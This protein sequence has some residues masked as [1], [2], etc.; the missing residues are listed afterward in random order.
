MVDAE[1]IYNIG[2]TKPLTDELETIAKTY[3]YF[4]TGQGTSPRNVMQFG[5]TDVPRTDAQLGTYTL[6]QLAGSLA[7]PVLDR[8]LPKPTHASAILL[9]GLESQPRIRSLLMDPAGFGQKN[10]LPPSLGLLDRTL[11]FPNVKRALNAP[12]VQSGSRQLLAPALG[13]GTST[14]AVD[15]T[16]LL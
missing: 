4:G 1:K 15:Q 14:F 10:V 11:Q 16:D 8:I 9:G 6:A 13:A 5:K 7:S 3:E 2:K 12:L